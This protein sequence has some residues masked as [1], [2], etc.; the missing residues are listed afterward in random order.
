MTILPWDTDRFV[1][2]RRLRDRCA[3]TAQPGPVAS[4]LFQEVEGA[5][6][7]RLHRLPEH[8]FAGPVS[9]QR[10]V[11]FPNV[12]SRRKEVASGTEHVGHL[13]VGVPCLEGQ[14]LK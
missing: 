5:L 1:P 2:S 4:L 6:R 10:A 3:T 12:R 7:G 14:K 13:V 9:V 11:L 8:D